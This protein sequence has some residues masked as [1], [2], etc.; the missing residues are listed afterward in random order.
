MQLFQKI[1]KERKVLNLF[2]E[3][4]IPLILKSGNDWKNKTKLQPRLYNNYWSKNQSKYYQKEYKIH[5][6]IIQPKQVRFVS[7]SISGKP[8]HNP[9]LFWIKDKKLLGH[10]HLWREKILQ[11]KNWLKSIYDRKGAYLDEQ[12]IYRDALIYLYICTFI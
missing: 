2:Y 5:L 6:K 8:L 1:G 4:S 7:S 3:R 12:I 10:L 9:D 11:N